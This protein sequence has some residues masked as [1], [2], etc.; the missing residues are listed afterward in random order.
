MSDQA[1]TQDR[2]PVA[3]APF[4]QLSPKAS[5]PLGLVQGVRAGRHAAQRP[6]LVNEDV[7]GRGCVGGHGG[8]D[9]DAAHAGA[10]RCPDAPEH[11]LRPGPAQV[12]LPTHGLEGP[13]QVHVDV[14]AAHHR[15][16][17]LR[18]RGVSQ[19]HRPPGHGSRRGQGARRVWRARRAF[20]RVGEAAG[21]AH[22]LVVGGTERPDQC[23]PDVAG[24][25]G[26]DDTHGQTS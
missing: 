22:H 2:N 14:G 6:R 4:G 17:V 13:G 20:R 9:D 25:A 1:G 16:Q 12:C 10:Q 26:D 5:F 11:G 15:P 3:R 18:R 8:Q 7:V 21:D 19:V 24:R 23:G